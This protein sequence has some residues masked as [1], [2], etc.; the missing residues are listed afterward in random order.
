MDNFELNNLHIPSHFT[1]PTQTTASVS[2]TSA[3]HLW[4]SR[5][6]HILLGQ[7]KSIMSSGLLGSIKIN[8]ID[9]LPCQLSKQPAF[10][11]NNSHSVLFAPFDL[12]YSDVWCPSPTITMG[13]SRYYVIFVDDFSRYTWIYLMKNRSEL[14]QI[15]FDFA[16]MIKTQFSCNIKVFRADNAQEYKEKC[17]L[18]FLRQNGTLPHHCCPSTSQQNG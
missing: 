12:I 5:L 13:G 2:S 9:C 14:P 1:S 17:V 11:F 3:F 8:I 16:N 7:L 4:H 6:G 15:Y 18:D 10:P